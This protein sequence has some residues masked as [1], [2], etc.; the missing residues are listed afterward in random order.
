MTHLHDGALQIFDVNH[1]Q[2][3]LL[4]MPSGF[5]HVYRVLIDCGHAVNF[6][7]SPWYPGAHLQS[8]GVTYIDMLVCT[9]YDEDHMSG[10]PDL[11]ARGITVG[12][13]LGNPTLSGEAILKLKT[14][15]GQDNLGKGIEAIAS[16][17]AARRQFGWAQVPPD[18][19]GVNMIWTWNPHSRFDDENNLSLVFT[20]DIHGHRFMFPGDMECEGWRHM[21]ATC[22]QFRPVVAGV[23]VLIASHHGRQS[24]IYQEMFSLYSCAPKLVVISDD[25]KQYGTQETTEFYSSKAIGIWGF[26][27]ALGVRKVLTTRSDGPIDFSFQGA[28]CYVY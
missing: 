26:R 3:A 27:T 18:I 11:D 17:L 2:C 4:T 7:G 10:Y 14:E 24:G 9:N 13:I 16:K 6:R 8:M 1:G 21:L 20:L 12:C 22:P 23:E 28:N 15:R 25:Y 5:G 19:P